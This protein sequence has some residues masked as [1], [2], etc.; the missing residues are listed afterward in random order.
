MTSDKVENIH[1]LWSLYVGE[2]HNYDHP[3]IKSDLINFFNE[4]EKKLPE[5]NKQLRQKDYVGNYNLYQSNYDL[6]LENN[7]VL[8]KLFNF[9]ANSI[10]KTCKIANKKI[11]EKLNNKDQKFKVN[12]DESWFIKYKDKGLVYPHIHDGCSWC[13]VYYVNIG[14]DAKKMNGSTFF[15]RP[16]S[17]TS[18]IDFGGKYLAND[19]RIFNAEEGKLLVWPNFLIHGSHPYEGQEK[20]IIISANTTVDLLEDA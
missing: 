20:R 13:C 6:H 15:L 5:G 8:K 16:Y 3:L 19:T 10:L 7:E 17:G 12:I 2:F 18:K 4:Y 9:I 1:S 14:K 11:I